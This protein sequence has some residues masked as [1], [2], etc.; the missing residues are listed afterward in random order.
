MQRVTDSLT[1]QLLQDVRTLRGLTW[2]EVMVLY[3]LDEEET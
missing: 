3:G 2:K 1:R